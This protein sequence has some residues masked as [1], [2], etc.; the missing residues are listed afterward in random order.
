MSLGAEIVAMRVYSS[1][2]RCRTG[3]VALVGMLTL[4]PP[5]SGGAQ[6]VPCDRGLLELAHGPQGYAPHGDRCEGIY[7]QQVS[8]T[9]L[10]VA[11]LT[12]SFEEYELMSGTDLTVEWTAPGDSAVRLRAQGVEQDLYYRMDAIRPTGSRSYHWPT[13]VLAAQHIA[14]GDIGA[15]GWTRYSLGGV[16]RDVYVPL[17]IRQHHADNSTST[18]AYDLVLL[19]TVTLREVYLTLAVVGPDGLR[20][21]M[22]RN[23][24]PLGI[25]YYPAE[26]PVKIRLGG[27]GATGIYYL[28][29]GAELESGGAVTLTQWIYHVHG[30][31]PH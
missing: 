14:R 7:A 22:I 24:E 19:P 18:N 3:A 23:G 30:P 2:Y 20:S 28:E 31:A 5:R 11:S 9:V 16:E 4:V 13:D 12:E 6:E 25:G 10:R 1:R 27:F 15:L 26:R 17:R 21:N 29:I 8:G